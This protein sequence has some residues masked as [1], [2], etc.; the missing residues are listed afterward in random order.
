MILSRDRAMFHFNQVVHQHGTPN[1]KELSHF[2]PIDTSINVD[3]I[4]AKDGQHSHVDIVQQSQIHERSLRFGVNGNDGPKDGIFVAANANGQQL[5]QPGILRRIFIHQPR[6]HGNGNDHAGGSRVAAQEGQTGNTRQEQFVPP[7][8]IQDIVGK[9][10]KEHE[11]DAQEGRIQ[12]QEFGGMVMGVSDDAQ[13]E[14]DQKDGPG[15]NAKG[16]GTAVIVVSWKVVCCY[17]CRIPRRLLSFLYEYCVVCF[18][19]VSMPKEAFT[20]D[21]IK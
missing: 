16:F 17:V 1:G 2:Q 11:T 4:G 19:V 21:K 3:G 5:S 14:A 10:Q 20:M 12:I 7:G 18:R 9:S 15:S 8:P 13:N 6:S